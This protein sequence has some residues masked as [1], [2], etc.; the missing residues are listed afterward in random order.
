M[1]NTDN[2]I[3]ES[4]LKSIIR[5]MAERYSDIRKLSAY[6]QEHKDFL[7]NL[8]AIPSTEAQMND[9]WKNASV[10]FASR[11]IKGDIFAISDLCPATFYTLEDVWL[12]DIKKHDAYI[13]WEK[14]DSGSPEDNYFLAAKNIRTLFRT[15]KKQSLENFEPIKEYIKNNYV[16]LG[17]FNKI[18]NPRLNMLIA[19][20]AEQIFGFTQDHDSENNWFLAELYVNMYY[21]NILA[22]IDGDAESLVKVLKAFQ[23]GKSPNRNYLIINAFEV[24]IAINFIDKNLLESVCSEPDKYDFS[25][26]Y[27][28]D[29]PSDLDCTSICNDRLLY[30][31]KSKQLEFSGVMSRDERDYLFSLVD[32]EQNRNAIKS[33]Y[34]IS[35]LEPY[36]SMIL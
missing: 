24:V 28:S 31:K 18:N 29:W 2:C 35:H 7:K 21:N 19:K 11:I 32:S 34:Y 13:I 3:N 8:R 9:D 27:S 30:D 33:L 1:K 26:V 5:N 25:M 36:E 10:D 17:N 23:F 20:K 15:T 4:T 14:N 16:T 6:Y 22:A 12:C